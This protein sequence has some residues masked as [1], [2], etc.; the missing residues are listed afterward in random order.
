MLSAVMEIKPDCDY[1]DFYKVANLVES[2]GFAFSNK[3]DGFDTLYWDFDFNGCTLTLSYNIYE[4]VTLY[5]GKPANLTESQKVQVR[6]L[7][8]KL[9]TVDNDSG[10]D[11]RR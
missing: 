7:A 1:A 10:F 5:A 6:S 11:G 3:I 2:M 9:K 4:G 8:A